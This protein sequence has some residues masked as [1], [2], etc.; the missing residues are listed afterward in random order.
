MSEPVTNTNGN[1]ASDSTSHNNGQAKTNGRAKLNGEARNGTARKSGQDVDN[2]I[3]QAEAVRTSLRDT[4]L[5][6]NDLLKGLKRHRRLNRSVQN[7][8]ASLRQ[9]RGLGV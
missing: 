5:K 2:L 8:L 3:R 1:A 9:L 6:T 4:L 7:T